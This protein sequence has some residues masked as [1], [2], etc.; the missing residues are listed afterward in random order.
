MSFVKVTNLNDPKETVIL[1]L[2]AIT[3][4]TV[5]P[6]E[7]NYCVCVCTSISDWSRYLLNDEDLAKIEIAMGVR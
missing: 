4:I 3:E 1:N 6:H 2:E 7:D 5:S